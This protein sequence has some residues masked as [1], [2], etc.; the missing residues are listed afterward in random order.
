MTAKTMNRREFLADCSF[1]V[2]GAGLVIN[3]LAAKPVLGADKGS[4][5]GHPK[6]MKMEYRTLGKTGLN[7]ATLS[8]GVMRLKEPAVLFKAL[9]LGI[10]YFDTAHGYQ[11]G[12]NERMLGKVA[13]EYGRKKILI[14]TKARPFDLRKEGQEKRQEFTKK[15]LDEKFEESLK[16]LQTD[17]VDVFFVH[18]I[19]DRSW[20]L[21]QEI[22]AFV[23]KIKKQ[24][25]AR[26]VGV[27]VHDE[28]CYVDA[29]DQTI[30]SPLYDVVLASLN[31]KS[32]QEHGEI[33]RKA[34]KA[35]LGVIAMKT[36]AG[37]YQKASTDTV[38][39]HQAALKWVLDKDFVDCAI[40]G[41]VNME[42]LEE[43]LGSVGKKV[44]WSDR[45]ILHSYYTS[46]KDRYCVSCGSCTATC[47]GQV[48]IPTVNR[49]LMYCEGYGDFELA[50]QAYHELSDRMNGVS[51]EG[52][53]LP[54]CICVNGINIPE[55]MKH[56]HALF[57]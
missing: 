31:F 19:Q 32:P 22:L 46:I 25:K 49:A 54:T 5:S 39:P 52:C 27:S 14:A 15:T 43:N 23:E 50:R 11:N 36:Q 47:T 1:K 3:Q 28:K 2:A 48:A 38:S 30:T 18:N 6:G 40:P 4:E 9:D 34:R 8:F 10:N 16:R 26:F 20:P 24:G 37:G 51:C 21:N 45:K 17:Y 33:L 35:N 53:T 57:A 29:I 42:Q 13:K 41:M 12:N 56:A 44:T 55:R 7:V